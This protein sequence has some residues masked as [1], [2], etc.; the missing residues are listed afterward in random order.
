[1]PLDSP[2]YLG[3][4]SQTDEDEAV[5]TKVGFSGGLSAMIVGGMDVFSV[6]FSEIMILGFASSVTPG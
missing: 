4:S 3:L 6:P 1:M 5:P 2:R